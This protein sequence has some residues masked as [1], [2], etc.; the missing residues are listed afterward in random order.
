MVSDT[1]EIPPPWWN[2]CQ[3]KKSTHFKP[4]AESADIDIW[5]CSGLFALHPLFVFCLFNNFNLL[6]KLFKKFE[7]IIQLMIK[8]NKMKKSFI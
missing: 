7:I 2:N 8:D 4:L 3:K 1:D 6:Y 5:V